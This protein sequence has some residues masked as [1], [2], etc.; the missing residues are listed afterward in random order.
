MLARELLVHGACS[1]PRAA[2]I[3][4]SFATT[5]ASPRWADGSMLL[6]RWSAGGGVD[7][8]FVPGQIYFLLRA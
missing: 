5:L 4:P 1:L 8:P 2:P 7:S 3:T 6:S